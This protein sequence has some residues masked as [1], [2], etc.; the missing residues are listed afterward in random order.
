MEFVL[1][2]GL[3]AAIHG[4]SLTT[5]DVDVCCRFTIDNLMRI[6]H[7]FEDQHP[8]HR[9]RPDLPVALTPEMCGQLKNLSIKTDLGVID[10]LGGVLIVGDFYEVLK[11]SLELDLPVGKL[12]ILDL[13][14]LIQAKK[15]MGRPH[16]LL[17]VKQLEAVKQSATGG[18]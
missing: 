4:S 8:V 14:T 9:M 10:C 17:T 5:R 7:A 11:H 2:G 13:D 18:S 12:R 16:D 1:V 15:A 3:A 6:Q